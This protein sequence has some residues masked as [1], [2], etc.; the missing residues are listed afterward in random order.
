MLSA[1]ATVMRRHYLLTVSIVISCH[2]AS[3]SKFVA[4]WESETASYEQLC[5]AVRDQKRHETMSC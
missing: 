4:M 2:V 1:H 5:T 3:K